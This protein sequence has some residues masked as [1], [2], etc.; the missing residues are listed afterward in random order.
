MRYESILTNCNAFNTAPYSAPLLEPLPGNKNL[1]ILLINWSKNFNE[2][3]LISFEN[4][5]LKLV[6]TITLSPVEKIRTSSWGYIQGYTVLLRL[7][8]EISNAIG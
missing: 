1:M 6:S 8:G 7:I 2:I 3:N 4:K 5:L